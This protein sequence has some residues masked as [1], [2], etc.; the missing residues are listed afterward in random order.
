MDATDCSLL[1]LISLLNY[2]FVHLVWLTVFVMYTIQLYALK[3]V[4][5]YFIHWF[6]IVFP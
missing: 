1:N 5:I 3:Y 6:Q 4:I 2:S